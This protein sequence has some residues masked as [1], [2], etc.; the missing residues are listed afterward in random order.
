MTPPEPPKRR[1][2]VVDDEPLAGRRLARRLA[3]AGLEVVAVLE[4]GQALLDGLAELRFDV[5]FLDIEMPEPNGLET[6]ALLRRRSEVSIVFVT[7]HDEHALAAFEVGALDYVLKPVQA[8]RLARAVQRLPDTPPSL[9]E[10]EALAGRLDPSGTGS[11]PAPATRLE[12]RDGA[13]TR[14]FEPRDVQRLTAADKYVVFTAPDGSEQVLDESLSQLENRL[15]RHGFVRVHRREL[16]RVD[17][18]VAIA[19]EGGK[20]TAELKNGEHADVSRRLAPVLRGRLEAS[21]RGR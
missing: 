17:A 5:A 18:V 16:I 6:A 14:Y 21:V 20:T 13:S 3:E 7:A 15:R 12:V 8:S 4:S 2:V 11:E 9:D 1:A 10:V 19:S